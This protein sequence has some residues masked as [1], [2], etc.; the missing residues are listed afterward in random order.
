MDG[1]RHGRRGRR[2]HPLAASARR[3][4]AALLLAFVALS[5]AVAPAGAQT[6]PTISSVAISFTPAEGQN[7]SYKIGDA[8]KASVLFDEAVDVTGVPQM[9]INVGGIQKRSWTNG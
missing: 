1:H 6:A 5:A 7:Q 2:A 3:A 4:A 8:V 9:E